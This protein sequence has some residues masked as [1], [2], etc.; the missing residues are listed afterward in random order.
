MRAWLSAL[1]AV[2]IAGAGFL[3]WQRAQDDQCEFSHMAIDGNVLP[4][5]PQ[6]ADEALQDLLATDLPPE[7]T[8]GNS[9]D[10]ERSES[11]D[12]QVTFV[13]GSTTIDAYHHTDGWMIQAL[14]TKCSP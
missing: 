3:L 10:Y 8:P 14:S 4:G 2:A 9:S 7:G 12:E 11:N 13:A 1:L 6:S 5:G